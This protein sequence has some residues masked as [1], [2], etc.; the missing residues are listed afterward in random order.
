MALTRAP[1][2]R[3]KRSANRTLAS[4]SRNCGGLA[5]LLTGEGC[6]KIT[7]VQEINIAIG[8][9]VETHAP[10]CRGLRPGREGR[11]AALTIDQTLIAADT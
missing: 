8:V 2:T 9:E 6:L 4:P 1:W 3:C 7:D 5:V 11:T 10:R